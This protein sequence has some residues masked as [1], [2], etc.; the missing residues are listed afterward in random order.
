MKNLELKIHP[1]VWVALFAVVGRLSA[2]IPAGSGVLIPYRKSLIV[3][4][5]ICAA[6]VMFAGLLAFAKA[7]TTVNPKTPER[8][9]TVVTRGIYQYTRNPMYLG[10]LFLLLAW[11]LYLAH[12]IPLLLLPLFVYLLNRVQIIPEERALEKTFGSHYRDYQQRV[13]R[14]L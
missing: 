9:S 11:A 10:F 12:L 4:L 7:R 8:S 1:P 3:L 5:V 13:R 6:A 2:L 14:W